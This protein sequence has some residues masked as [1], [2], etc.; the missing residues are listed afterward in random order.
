VQQLASDARDLAKEIHVPA[1]SRWIPSMIHDL[2]HAVRSLLAAPGFTLVALLILVLSIGASTAIYSVIDA[3][4]LRGLPYDQSDRLMAVG[5]LNVKD[6]SAASRNLVAPQNYLDWRAQQDVFTGLAAINDVSISLKREG[7][8]DPEILR[9]QMVTSEFFSVLGAAPMLGRAF[10]IDNEVNGRARV[11]VI[12]YGLWQRRFGGA[13]DVLAHVL[14]GQLGDFEIVGVMPPAFAYPAGATLPTDVWVPYAPSPEDHVRGNSF[15]YN[16]QVIGRLRDG[17]SMAA[18]Q[19]RMDQITAALAAATPRWFTDRVAKVEP[20]RESLTRGV[21]TWMV[22]LLAAVTFVMLI[23]CVNLANLMLVRATTRWRDLGIRAAL[24]ASSWN[25]SRS[26]LAESLTLSLVGAALGVLLAWIG[27]AVLRSAMPPDVPRVGAIAVNLRV[28]ATTGVVAVLTGLA[29]G[30]APVWQFARPAAAGALVQRDRATTAGARARRLRAVFVITEVALAV[31]LLV[32]AGLFLASF[33]RVSSVDLGLDRRDVL[34]ARIRPLV[35]E[36]EYPDAIAHNTERLQAVL[37]RVRVIPGV[38]LASLASGGLPMRGDLRTVD[39]AIPGRALPRDTDIALNQISPEYFTSLRIPMLKGRAFTDADRPGADPVVILN[40]A[41]ARKFFP[42]ADPVGATVQLDGLRTVVG[43]AGSI[44]YDGPEAGSRTQAFI[45]LAQSRV[46]GATLLLRTATALSTVIP[47]VKTAIWSEFPDVP[48]PDVATLEEYFAQL[49]AARRFNMLLLGLFGLVGI[50]I[51]A[52]GIYG[53]MAY[54]VA[55]R[56]QEIGIRLALGAA[57]GRILRSVLGR[58]SSYLAA[59]IAL[60]LAGAW[61]LTGVVTGFLFDTPPHDP[62]VF[63]GVLAVLAIT[64]LAAAAL[65]ARRAARV[66]PLGV[67]RSH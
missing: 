11:A 50:A 4:M 5:E 3:V 55:E 13:P 39:F 33:G 27:V 40:D 41:A 32:G 48:L 64:G 60:G 24:G 30:L 61:S 25:L 65:P 59:G 15:G 12:S 23:A 14:P 10:T 58:A 54:S 2:R 22:L 57:P 35:G 9:A 63:T 18:A 6:A 51:A 36:R 56:R 20:L 7:Q 44:R 37:E 66:D 26:V 21:R 62:V 34:T 53:V 31:V 38:T 52:I 46:L 45:P 47:S 17:V 67:L 19:A 8:A 28:L 1:Y 49:T 16:L 42:G 43:V 29:F